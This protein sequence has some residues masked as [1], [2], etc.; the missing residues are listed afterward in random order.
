MP[1]WSVPEGREG[2]GRTQR[3]GRLAAWSCP[4][5]P[6]LPS[7]SRGEG[8]E[9]RAD[10]PGGRG[11]ASRPRP[12]VLDTGGS[13]RDP[14]QPTPDV[15][16]ASERAVRDADVLLVVGTS[17][18]VH[19]AAGLATLAHR[20]GRRVVEINPDPTPI[21]PDVDLSLQGP[22]GAILPA[23]VAAFEFPPS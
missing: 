10:R 17:A 11:L 4:A 5:H 7:A 9:G 21:T 8:G 20:L 16:D 18:V 14:C 3:E 6:T 12:G 23:L 22:A 19:P 15:W 2:L 13:K 1:R